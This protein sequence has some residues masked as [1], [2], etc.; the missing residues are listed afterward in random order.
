MKNALTSSQAISDPWRQALRTFDQDLQRRGAADRTRKA[1]G[2]DA[3]EL[4]AW[5]TANRLEPTEVDY[6]APPR[7]AARGGDAHPARAPR[8]RLQGP[9]TRAPPP[10]PER[11]GAENDGPQAREHPLA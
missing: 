7:W 5:A 11:R 9:A 6:K 2:T 4:A 8:G 3:A 1:Y 10:L